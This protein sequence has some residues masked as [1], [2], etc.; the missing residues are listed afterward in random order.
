MSL[1]RLKSKRLFRQQSYI[2]G[3]WRDAADGSTVTVENPANGETLGTIPSLRLTRSPM[4]LIRRRRASR[5]GA[6][7]RPRSGRIC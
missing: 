4:R 6:R 3:Q 7:S 1:S 5:S 2:G